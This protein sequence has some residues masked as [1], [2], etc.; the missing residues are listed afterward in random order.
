MNNKLDRILTVTLAVCAL[1]TTGLVLHRELSAPPDPVSG[2]PKPRFVPDWKSE[3]TDGIQLGS[4]NAPV[5]IIEFADFECPY[6]ADFHR[7]VQALRQRYPAKVALTYVHLP[8]PMHRFAIAAARAAECAGEQGRF[9][10]MHD[11]LFEEQNSF[12]LKPWADY[13]AEA[14]VEN[15]ATFN[16][17]L[18]RSVPFARIEQGKHAADR[19]NIKATPTLMVN[20]WLF[21][22]PPS[23][24][25]LDTQVRAIL[26]GRSPVPST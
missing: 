5:Q 10:G 16:A 15:I 22:T 8:L 7:V 17:C 2:V 23:A 1:F 11:R 19:L 20:G 14:G 21:G 13:A 26:A 3:F 4:T 12:G 24:D 9:E 18:E 6:C 25:Q